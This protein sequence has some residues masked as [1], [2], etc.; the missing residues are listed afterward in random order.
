MTQMYQIQP[1]GNQFDIIVQR[2]IP[3]Q[4]RAVSF[5]NQ[6]NNALNSSEL[7]QG[8][9]AEIQTI[10]A[11]IKTH[12]QSKHPWIYKV[13]AYLNPFSSA[14]KIETLSKEILRVAQQKDT[15]VLDK[16]DKLT[17][18]AK[19]NRDDANKPIIA[20]DSVMKEIMKKSF[21]TKEKIFVYYN[22][23]QDVLDFR[24]KSSDS[25]DFWILPEYSLISLEI[26]DKT[27]KIIK[28]E[29][30]FDPRVLPLNVIKLLREST[31]LPENQF[32]VV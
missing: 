6:L 19:N 7:K 4:N 20:S 21:G 14:Y 29:D 27:R 5:L 31:V 9:Y 13:Q 10:L 2:Q 3:G 8:Q 17:A 26:I 25:F 32:P 24:T 23:K 1:K 28:V 30:I 16:L 11:E 18:V 22:A 15:D 12:C